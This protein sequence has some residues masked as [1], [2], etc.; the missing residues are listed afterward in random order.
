[1][2]AYQIF[3]SQGR[4][5]NLMFSGKIHTHPRKGK[6]WPGYR[7]FVEQHKRETAS[8]KCRLKTR[9]EM[10]TEGKMQTADYTRF[11]YTLYCVISIIEC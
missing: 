9:G 4:Q 3:A 8:V 5:E 1:M 7:Y 10:Q 6:G 2:Y 11:R